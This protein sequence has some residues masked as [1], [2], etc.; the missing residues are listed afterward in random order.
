MFTLEETKEFSVNHENTKATST[1]FAD[2][3]LKE[4]MAKLGM[5]PKPAKKILPKGLRPIEIETFADQDEVSDRRGWVEEQQQLILQNLSILAEQL[6]DP[7]LAAANRE[8]ISSCEEEIRDL[9]QRQIPKEWGGVERE[10]IT[11]FVMRSMIELYPVTALQRIADMGLALGFFVIA[12]EKVSGKISLPVTWYEGWRWRSLDSNFPGSK[13]LV[14]L[15]KKRCES[16]DLAKK[17]EQRALVEILR[18]GTTPFLKALEEGGEAVVYVPTEQRKKDGVPVMWRGEDGTEKPVMEPK[19]HLLAKVE[20]GFVKPIR[21]PKLGVA[22]V[23]AISRQVEAM[24]DAEVEVRVSQV[25]KGEGNLRPATRL[26]KELYYQYLN[27]FKF[28]C[29]GLTHLRKKE[30]ER[31]VEREIRESL[32]LKAT[33]DYRDWFSE[34]APVGTT[35][36]KV[37]RWSVDRRAEVEEYRNIGIVVERDED[38]NVRVVETT[39][40]ELFQNCFEFAPEEGQQYPLKQ[41]L[42]MLKRKIA[43]GNGGNGSEE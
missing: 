19:G 14:P 27:F 34:P 31:E 41:M 7:E 9:V 42:M 21:H 4:R 12:S 24:V 26:E 20:N 15:L 11:L 36:L 35:Y 29:R 25:L 17:E 1:P 32:Q 43:S 18:Q 30:A 6:T 22:A 37:Y 13:G 23:G 3:D 28:L 10:Q 39:H 2:A 40:P 38:G 33:V 16:F 8:Q 5:K